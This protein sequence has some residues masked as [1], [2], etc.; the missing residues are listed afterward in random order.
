MNDSLYLYAHEIDAGP[1]GMIWEV[2][3]D[4]M[5]YIL[6]V[7]ADDFGDWLDIARANDYDVLVSTFESWLEYERVAAE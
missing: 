4:G 1:M 3:S 5:G 2:Y 6:S 7:N